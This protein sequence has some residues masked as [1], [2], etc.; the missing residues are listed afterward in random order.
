MA[1]IPGGEY[2]FGIFKE[3]VTVKP[4]C[5]DVNE[6]SAD[7]YAACVKAG[8]CDASYL[9]VCDPKTYA[10]AGRGKMSM[11]CVDFTQAEKYCAA[12][13]KR[14]PS[15]EEWEWAARGGA[16]ARSHPWG[17]APLGDQLCWGGKTKRDMPCEVGS[18]PAGDNPQGVHDLLGGVLEWTTSRND[19]TTSTRIVR[20][21]SW[22]D[23]DPALFKV[24]RQGAFKTTYRCGFLGIRCA[25]TAP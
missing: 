18:F 20:G 3:K 4:F 21:G 8:K 2:V 16:E 25:K 14:L 13:D 22:K 24:D 23:G 10:T 19:A 17:A 1:L 5:L 11:V 6:V 9:D 15:T 7:A 12:Y